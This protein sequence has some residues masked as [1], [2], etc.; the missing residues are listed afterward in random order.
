[1]DVPKIIIADD[2][3]G[4]RQTLNKSISERI[5]CELYEASTGYEA[6]AHLKEKGCDLMLLDYKMPGISG[7]EVLRE[8]KKI[9]PD[10]FVFVITKWDSPE[11]SREVQK[12]GAEYIPKPLTLKFLLTK[13][14]EKLQTINKYH[15][16]VP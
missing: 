5:H 14:Q 4:L 3:E 15:P 7:L 8:V 9:T 12:L 1:M 10:A 11:V 16:V 2:E 13:I 6:L